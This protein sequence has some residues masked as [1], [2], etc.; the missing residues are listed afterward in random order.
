MAKETDGELVIMIQAGGVSRERAL[1]IIYT[2]SKIKVKLA[3]MILYNNGNSQDG[4][5]MYQEAIIV[6]D[7][8]IRE[9]NFRTEGSLESYLFSIGKFLWMNQLRKKKLT[10]KEKFS[11]HEMIGHGIEPDHL[12]IDEERKAQLKELLSKL[13]HRCQDILSLWQLSYSMEEIANKLGLHDASTARKAKYD[14][15]QQLIKIVTQNPFTKSE[16]S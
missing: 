16:L 5:D 2:N 1:K 12:L 11:D 6:M 9:G 13:G 8:N 14:C 15:Q 3:S 4:E 7:K 10:L